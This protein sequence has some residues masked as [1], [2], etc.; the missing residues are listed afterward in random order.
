MARNFDDFPT[1]DPV[2]QDKVYLSGVWSNF[3]A[4]FVESLQDYL[5]QDGIF[6]PR[7]TSEQR[8]SL[9]NAVNGQLIY[10]TS[11]NKFQGFE[12]GI[13]KDFIQS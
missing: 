7:V 8:D 4:T 1:Y 6:V 9:K 5:S 3:L 10:N 12:S 13:W 11:T 2:V